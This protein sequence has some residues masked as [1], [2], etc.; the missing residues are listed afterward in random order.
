MNRVYI[1]DEGRNI[2]ID[3]KD[4]MCGGYSFY[5]DGRVEQLT[6]K[7]IFDIFKDFLLSEDNKKLPNEG[8]YKVYLDNKT[9]FK[10]YFHNGEESFIMFFLNNGEDATA[11]RE[12]EKKEK[13]EIVLN[14]STAKPHETTKEKSFKIGKKIIR[15][16]C[17]AL[18]MTIV[19]AFTTNE[20]MVF[21]N[22]DKAT[23]YLR[24]NDMFPFFNY[25][26][27]NIGT[28]SDRLMGKINSSIYL[29]ED[30]KFFLANKEFLEDVTSYINTSGFAKSIFSYR[31]NDVFIDAYD[32]T[33]KEHD[34]YYSWDQPNAL[35][36]AE[37]YVKEKYTNP[38]F[39]DIL[40]HEYI[41]SCQVGN[42]F[43][44]ITEASAEIISYEYFDKSPT[45]SYSEEVYLIRKLMEVIGPEPIW[46][47]NFV[48]SFDEIEKAVKPYL[49]ELE[50]ETFLY[51]LHRLNA[52]D[53]E[54]DADE[55]K[56][57]HESLN[58][59][60]DKIYEKKYGRPSSTDSVIPYLKKERIVRHYF[61]HRKMK[62]CQ[63][64][65]PIS[66]RYD[67]EKIPIE[68][69]VKRQLV[70]ICQI[71]E[72]GN[73]EIVS[74]DEYL[75]STYD[76]NRSLH[77]KT[78]TGINFTLVLNEQGRYDVYMKTEGYVIPLEDAVRQG[79]IYIYQIDKDG[80]ILKVSLKNYLKS[81]YDYDLGLIYGTNK[82][83]DFK[84]FLGTDGRLH[85]IIKTYEKGRTIFF[86]TVEEKFDRSLLIK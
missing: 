65:V 37:K 16:T 5:D 64:Y 72:D 47:Y 79:L 76:V 44:I 22:E 38:R 31:F 63:S 52:D 21:R 74:W 62:E 34:G 84:L 41:H 20:L 42:Y 14:D 33:D 51:D 18:L 86:P 23:H 4:R 67:M 75:N 49:T 24:K 54:Y 56:E 58:Y 3:S 81:N 39:W 60:L 17:M 69:A 73:E 15:S 57:K 9:G 7:E 30:E 25:I 13:K 78:N 10:H 19:S 26:I 29:E 68:D 66:D 59:L 80:N 61:N 32:N 28:S 6:N 8:K 85:A 45:D 11:Y 36:I 48:G 35:H 43:N 12:E 2:I 46:R 55:V 1:E 27:D 50:Y 70:Y 71:D 53:P 77:F 82:D 83:I 40:S